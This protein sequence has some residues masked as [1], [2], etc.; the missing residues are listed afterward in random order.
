MSRAKQDQECIATRDF[1]NVLP[2]LSCNV[3]HCTD[4]NNNP[5]IMSR[6]G[7]GFLNYSNSTVPSP[8]SSC[9]LQS[10]ESECTL[11][12]TYSTTQSSQKYKEP[13]STF[14]Q[15]AEFIQFGK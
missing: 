8:S 12:T 14:V 10:S 15:L 6:S 13:P 5:Q 9:G 7:S 1:S 4:D 3:T 2:K 11:H